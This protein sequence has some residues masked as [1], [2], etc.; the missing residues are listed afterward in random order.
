MY[1]DLLSQTLRVLLKTQRVEHYEMAGYGTV[2]SLAQRLGEEAAMQLL[3][4]TLLEEGNAD[5]KL[6]EIAESQVN[7][8]AAETQKL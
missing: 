1:D 5:H 2:R 7:L 3:Q 4:A 6:T 8:S